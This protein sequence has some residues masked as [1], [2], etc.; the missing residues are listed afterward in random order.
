M[1]I[2]LFSWCVCSFDQRCII[3]ASSK[4]KAQEIFNKEVRD[5]NRKEVDA[6][7]PWAAHF[8]SVSNLSEVYLEIYLNKNFTID[9][10]E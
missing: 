5:K 3:K 9:Y 1:N 10:S 2:Y 8:A 4:E 6:A 7:K